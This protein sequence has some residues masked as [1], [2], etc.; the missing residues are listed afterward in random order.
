M[1][2]KILLVD[3]PSTIA[4]RRDLPRIG[5]PFAALYLAS[6]LRR[7]GFAPVMYDPK[8]NVDIHQWK[9]VFYSGDSL[10]QIG[11]RISAEMP[12]FIGITNLLSK[13]TGVAL[14][15]SRQAKA[16]CPKAVVAIGGFHATAA[17]HDILAFQDTDIA[18]MG[19]GEQTVVELAQCIEAKGSFAGIKG[20]AY[21][22]ATGSVIINPARPPCDELPPF[23]DYGLIDMEQYFRLA[24]RGFGA[25]P[26]SIGRRTMSLFTSRGCPFRCFF[27]GAHA[28]VGRRFR[29]YPAAVVLD[30]IKEM[31]QRYKVDS[32]EFE[33]DNVSADQK[34]FG[35]LVDGL[36]A[37]RPRLSWATPNGVRADTLVDRALLERIKA[38]GCRYLTIGVE[39]GDQ[40]FLTGTI[41]KSLDLNV[42]TDLAKLCRQVGIPLNAFFIVGFPDETLAQM[43]TTLAFAHSLHR[44]WHVYPFINFA[45][46]LKGTDMYRVCAEKGYLAGELTPEVLTASMS[47]RGKGLIATGDFTPELVGSLMMRFNREVLLDELK[48]MALHPALAARRVRSVLNSLPRVKRYFLG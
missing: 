43:R 26:L 7:A 39:S 13:D 30:H 25:R 40:G 15:I 37:F 9:T 5:V 23:P 16:V 31:V 33:D 19:E 8:L 48:A 36:T 42:V 10:E 18:A 24:A 27:C 41:Q 34:R 45:I 12:D 21:R 47:Y 3:T 44:R 28:I 2:I 1:S 32:V 11:S 6:S 38:S 20:I 14:A 29:A 46:P 4:T 22:D 35:A 17:P